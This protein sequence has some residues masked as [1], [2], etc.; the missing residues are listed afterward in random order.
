MKVKTYVEKIT[1]ID[2]YENIVQNQMLQ[3]S[4]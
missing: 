2:L 3:N 1:Y 4:S